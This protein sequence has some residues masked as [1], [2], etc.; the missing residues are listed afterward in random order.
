MLSHLPLD[1]E[2]NH[3]F[4]MEDGLWRL[5]WA[6]TLGRCVLRREVVHI[7]VDEAAV[8]IASGEVLWVPPQH[9]AALG[10][11]TPV[12]A[13]RRE[14]LL[15]NAFLCSPAAEGIKKWMVRRRLQART[16]DTRDWLARRALTRGDADSTSDA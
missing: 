13:V 14:H 6:N 8:K 12:D 2:L 1:D 10:T 7:D 9:F 5:V 11:D 15:L 16:S 4:Y 3:R